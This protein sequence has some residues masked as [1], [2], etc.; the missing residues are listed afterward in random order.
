MDLIEQCTVKGNAPP[1]PGGRSA[2]EG[3][4]FEHEQSVKNAYNLALEVVSETGH[5][6]AVFA[7]GTLL[8]KDLYDKVLIE[9]IGTAEQAFYFGTYTVKALGECA[10]LSWKEV[11]AIHAEYRPIYGDLSITNLRFLLLPHRAYRLIPVEYPRLQTFG[12]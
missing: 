4:F 6:M 8:P 2:G 7:A 10:A 12:G 9:E 5:P 3:A 1:G 11:L